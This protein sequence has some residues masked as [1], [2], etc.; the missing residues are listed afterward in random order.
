MI[1]RI[2]QLQLNE[3]SEWVMLN[4][5][6]KGHDVSEMCTAKIDKRQ[7]VEQVRYFTFLEY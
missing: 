6:K 4:T 5:F 1:F 2:S 7:L 3:F